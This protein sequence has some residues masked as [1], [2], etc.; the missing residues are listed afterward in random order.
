MTKQPPRLV[1]LQC[2]ILLL[3]LTPFIVVAA[4]VSY[5]HQAVQ[6]RLA[7]MEP[8]H[9]RLQGINAKRPELL[10]AVQNASQT[11]SRY[12]YPASVD[13]ARAGNEAQQLIR[14]AFESGDMTIVSA[15]VLDPKDSEGFHR[16]RLV[17]LVEGSLPDI[18]AALLK[19]KAQTPVVMVESLSMQSQG[20]PR[21][22]SN[23]RVTC[24][25][26]FIALRA[27]S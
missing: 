7:E 14:S 20:Q 13:V 12:F 6:A 1:V 26:N 25:L 2:L 16:I 11:V 19:L 15:Q 17:F 24:N 5:A 3:A 18:Q 22:G 21:P 23:V 9:A 4:Y 10:A 8:R 27:K